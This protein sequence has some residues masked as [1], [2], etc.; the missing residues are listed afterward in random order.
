[1]KLASKLQTF[2]ALL[3]QL[4][5]L[6]QSTLCSPLPPICSINT[7]AAIFS[8]LCK[9]NES[10]HALQHLIPNLIKYP[11]VCQ[12]AVPPLPGGTPYL[13]DI[14]SSLLSGLSSP[15]PPPPL[16]FHCPHQGR[17]CPR[18]IPSLSLSSSSSSSAASLTSPSEVLHKGT[19]MSQAARLAPPMMHCHNRGEVS[20][21]NKR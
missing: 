17:R 10:P 21:K 7:A 18:S 11:V 2:L 9:L 14:A 19:P 6:G 16:L 8:S 20:T 13:L 5:I 1:M 3:N 4:D 15:P 12:I